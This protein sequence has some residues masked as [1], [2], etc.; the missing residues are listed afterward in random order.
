MKTEEI[1]RAI[2]NI[3]KS[4]IKLSNDYP[5][6]LMETRQTSQRLEVMEEEVKKLREQV[7]VLLEVFRGL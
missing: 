1:E 6:A 7:N 4:F 5:L 3:E 2:S